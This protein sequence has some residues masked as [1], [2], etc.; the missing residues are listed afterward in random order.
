[1]SA[2]GIARSCQFAPSRNA[3]GPGPGLIKAATRSFGG[4]TFGLD[5]MRHAARE[6]AASFLAGMLG[7]VTQGLGGDDLLTAARARHSAPC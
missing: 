2:A 6:S 5:A 1:M 7:T 4:G 3:V